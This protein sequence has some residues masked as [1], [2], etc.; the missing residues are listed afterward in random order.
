M[1]N[2][3]SSALSNCLT[4][5][6]GQGNV[7]FPSKPFFQLSDVKPYNLDIPVSPL[8]VTYPTSNEQVAGV[9]KCAADNNAKVQAKSGGHSYGNFGMCLPKPEPMTLKQGQKEL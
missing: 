8:A 1:G 6:V 4:S 2:Q 7:A 5:V 9:V 3:Q